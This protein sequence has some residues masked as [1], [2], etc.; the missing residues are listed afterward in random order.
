M[1]EGLHFIDLIFYAMIAVFLVLR[2]RSVLGRRQDRERPRVN[3]CDSSEQTGHK[4]DNKTDR[5]GSA[6][7]NV[8]ALSVR[9]MPPAS[10]VPLE[11][12]LIQMQMADSR[13]KT[14]SFLQGAQAAFEIIIKAFAIGDKQILRPLLSDPVFIDF[15]SAIN[16]RTQIGES[17]EIQLMETPAVEIVAAKVEGQMAFITLCFVSE[18]INVVRDR[19][20]KTIEGNPNRVNKVVDVW[21]FVRDLRSSDPNW[22]LV[23]TRSGE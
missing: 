23:A 2:L 8:V 22:T 6:V 20:G 15:S 13:F 21:T 17:T 14:E 11:M 7:N 5:G 4:T 3:S 18:Q 10:S 19:D 16:A 1:G 9:A 12:A